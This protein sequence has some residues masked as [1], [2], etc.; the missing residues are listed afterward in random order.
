MKRTLGLLAL[1]LLGLGLL[2]GAWAS[3]LPI[4]EWALALDTWVQTHPLAA[5]L[6]LL[7]FTWLWSLFLPTMLPTVLGGFWFG[8]LLGSAVIYLATAAAFV[9]SF[10]VARHCLHAGA[11]RWLDAR[12]RLACF[13]RALIADGWRTV[14]L[15]RLSPVLPFSVQNWCYGASSIGFWTCLSA[16]LVGKLPNTVLTVAIGALARDG[17]SLE[18]GTVHGRFGLALTIAASLL[19]LWSLARSARRSLRLAGASA[20]EAC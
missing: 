3:G 10:L 1:I 17:L 18:Q 12:P 14:L 19:L 2:F 7:L 9:A 11:Q 8:L 20:I 4:L 15:M 5:A 13:Q 16:T 6:A